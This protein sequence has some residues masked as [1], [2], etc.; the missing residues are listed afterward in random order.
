MST[1]TTDTKRRP[2]NIDINGQA[3]VSSSEHYTADEAA[4][5]QRMLVEVLNWATRGRDETRATAGALQIVKDV[6]RQANVA[7]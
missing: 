2:L 6:R 4:D 1:T 5:V 7:S 3:V